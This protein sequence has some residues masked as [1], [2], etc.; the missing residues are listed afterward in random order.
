MLAQKKASFL[1]CH[2]G[3]SAWFG[4]SDTLQSVKEKKLFSKTKHIINI[5]VLYYCS[6]SFMSINVY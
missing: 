4:D 2:F 5:V 1:V 6:G 3:Q